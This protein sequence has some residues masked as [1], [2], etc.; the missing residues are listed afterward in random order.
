MNALCRA[1][2]LLM[3]ATLASARPCMA[4]EPEKGG[5]LSQEE[6]AQLA[7]N[8]VANLI[9]IP[10]ENNF[11]YNVGPHNGNQYVGNFQPVIPFSPTENWK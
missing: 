8:P 3:V 2:C 10:I 4:A 6:L 11:N 1:M 5:R 9:S 7:Q